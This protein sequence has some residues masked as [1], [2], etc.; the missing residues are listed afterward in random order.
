MGSTTLYALYSQSAPLIVTATYRLDN[1]ETTSDVIEGL[2][3]TFSIPSTVTEG[4]IAYISIVPNGNYEFFVSSTDAFINAYSGGVYSLEPRHGVI[5]VALSVECWTLHQGIGEF[6]ISSMTDEGRGAVV[7]LKASSPAGL[8]E[9]ALHFGGV[10]AK[11]FAE[12]TISEVKAYGAIKDEGMDVLS[13]SSIFSPLTGSGIHV[14]SGDSLVSSNVRLHDS[15]AEIFSIYAIYKYSSNAVATSL[16]YGCL[17]IL[18][19]GI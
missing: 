2:C 6:R 8:M 10:Y 14:V 9:G 3:T 16:Q 15:G 13:D 11:V 7:M 4:S 18:N 12:D 1:S 19:G 5:R 17:G